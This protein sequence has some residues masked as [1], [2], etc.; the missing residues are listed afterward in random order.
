MPLWLFAAICGALPFYVHWNPDRFGPPLMRFDGAI[1]SRDRES[2]AEE[3]RILA[4]LLRPRLQLDQITTGSISRPRAVDGN[5]LGQNQQPNL[6]DSDDFEEQP[7]QFISATKDRALAII[8][9]KLLILARGDLLPDGRSIASFE[10]TGGEI[11]PVAD[12]ALG[13]TNNPMASFR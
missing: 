4:A 11:R 10:F 6:P 12:A 2:Q 13:S 8:D 5:R 3:A 7:I 1:E 9:G